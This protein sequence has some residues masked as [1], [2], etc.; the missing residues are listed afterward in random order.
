MKQKIDKGI[1]DNI[2]LAAQT[3]HNKKGNNLLTLDVRG[4]SCLTD[5]L[6][7]AEGNINRHVIAIAKEVLKSMKEKDVEPIYVEGL[8]NGDWVVLDFSD[9]MIHLFIPS[10]REKY[11]LERLWPESKL[12]EL[13]L[14]SIDEKLSG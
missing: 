9:F 14:S 3:I 6:L 5:Y 8:G 4:F 13:T 11:Q 1:M 2:K 12:V 10:F 7:I